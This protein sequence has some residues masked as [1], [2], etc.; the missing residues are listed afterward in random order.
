MK[1][2]FRIITVCILWLLSSSCNAKY[3]SSI[4]S[5]LVTDEND[6]KVSMSYQLQSWYDCSKE[7]G[8]SH[9]KLSF[10]D[11]RSDPPVVTPTS[12]QIVHKTITYAVEK[13]SRS[14]TTTATEEELTEITAD[15]HQFY[16][17]F[18]KYW[19]TFLKV[20]NVNECQKHDGTTKLPNGDVSDGPLCPLKP[21]T[22]THIF[23]VHPPLNRHT[24]YGIYRSR[25]LYH[26]GRT[27]E[28]IG[29]VDMQ[30]QYVPDKASNVIR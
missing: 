19:I 22:P 5:T 18:H 13:N 8:I 29:C 28:P 27:T 7:V 23:T 6:P 14:T 2:C 4:R 16:Y 20:N 25:Q 21:N 24:P 11:V 17:L 3:S 12:G 1:K 10:T 15:F 26:N 9:P 30:F